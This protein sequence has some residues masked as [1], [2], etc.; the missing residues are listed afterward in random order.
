MEF[1]PMNRWLKRVTVPGRF[2]FMSLPGSRGRP[3]RT[4]HEEGSRDPLCIYVQIRDEDDLAMLAIPP[5]F[6]EVMK[7]W[8]TIKLS[9]V[10]RLSANKWCK[11]WVQNFDDRWCSAKAGYTSATQTRSSPTTLTCCCIFGVGLKIQI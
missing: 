6:M 8:L 11:F 4:R 9:R 10:V 7:D 1:I 5:K 2:A 3:S